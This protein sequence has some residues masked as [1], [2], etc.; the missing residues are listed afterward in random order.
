MS[1]VED[2]KTPFVS[3]LINQTELTGESELPD[4]STENMVF[5]IMQ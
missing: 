3:V 5:P 2:K 4:A 1:P